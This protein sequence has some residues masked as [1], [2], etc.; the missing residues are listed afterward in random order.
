MRCLRTAAVYESALGAAVAE[1]IQPS[2]AVVV[3]CFDDR[4][5]LRE[6]VDSIRSDPAV[7]ELVVVDDGSTEPE[8]I[9]VLDELERE[10]VR[11]SAEA[12][13]GRRRRR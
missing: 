4:A 1:S 9:E 10:G 8:T 3:T 2:V 6:A 11:V 7:P 5:T 13:R 12:N